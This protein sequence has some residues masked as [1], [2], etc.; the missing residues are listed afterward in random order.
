MTFPNIWNIK[1][2]LFSINMA[3]YKKIK[4]LAEDKK[5]TQEELGK[6]LNVSG[7]TAHN[8]LNG[9]TKIEADL[10]P[11]IAKI[12]GVTISDLFDDPVK[13]FKKTGQF[14]AEEPASPFPNKECTDPRC[15]K[16]IKRL[17][18]IIDD[19]SDDKLRLKR[20][21]DDDSRKG[22][23][24]PIKYAEGGVEKHSKTG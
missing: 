8:Y 17:N 4:K 12:L 24:P 20:Q 9:H 2:Q 14:K 19:L 1:F 6:E 10:L 16:E 18:R 3:I 15:Q 7:K 21:L 11:G 5:L 13:S 22:D 23:K